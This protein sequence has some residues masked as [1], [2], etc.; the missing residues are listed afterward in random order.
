M[1]HRH[2]QRSGVRDN[3]WLRAYVSGAH[4]DGGIDSRTHLVERLTWRPGIAKRVRVE[5][6]CDLAP[7]NSEIRVKSKSCHARTHH[8]MSSQDLLISCQ[9]GLRVARVHA[10][11]PHQHST[12]LTMLTGCRCDLVRHEVI[13]LW[14]RT[15]SRFR[16]VMCGV[17]RIHELKVRLRPSTRDTM[18]K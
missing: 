16:L 9:N 6:M 11:A 8:A 12:G 18:K 17:G 5:H 4:E 13:K 1:E 2:R 3:G 15:S 7:A 14:W 10:R